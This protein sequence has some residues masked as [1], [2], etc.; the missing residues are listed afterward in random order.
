MRLIKKKIMYS[1]I[2][3]NLVQIEFKQI[4]IR[5]LLQFKFLNHLYV[6]EPR[7]PPVPLIFFSLKD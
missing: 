7:F 3:I 1:E 6:P 4:F 5:Q 2:L